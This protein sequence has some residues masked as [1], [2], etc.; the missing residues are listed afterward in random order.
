MPDFSADRNPVEQLAEEFAQ[1]Y[2]CGERPSLTDYVR[3][4]PQ[5]ADEIRELFP[6]LVAMEQLKPAT[7]DA[8]GAF[9]GS[10]DA[11]TSQVLDRLGDYRIVREVGRGGMGVVYEAEQESLGRHVA[12]KVL[13]PNARLNPTYLERFRREAKAAARLHHTNIVPVYGVGEEDGVHFYAMQFIRGEGL[14]RVLH[15][16]RRLRGAAGSKGGDGLL[17]GASFEASVAHNLLSGQFATPH[18][19]AAAPPEQAATVPVGG[20]EAKSFS[21]LSSAGTETAYFR[22]VA[23]VGLQVADALAYAHRQGVVHR[24]IKPSNLLLDAQGTVWVADF[25]LAKAEGSD[26][27]THTGDIVGTLRFMAPERF[28]GRSLPQSDIYSL[29]LTLYELLTLRPAFDDT[30]KGRLVDKVLHEPPPP[31][32]RLDPRVP[33][34]LETVVLKCVA[35]DP[36]ER[37][38]TADA[39][40]EEL[41]RFLADRPIRARR[42]SSAEK[43]WRWARRNPTVASLLGCVAL[44]LVTVAVVSTFSAAQM[45]AA[46]G[47]TTAAEREARLREAE[48]LLGQAH[49]TRYSR[50]G[51][52]RFETLAALDKAAAI[53]R[54]L[55]Q[56][57]QW[58]DRLR[59]EAIACLA[60]PDWRPLREWDGVIHGTHHW[61]CDD[62]HRLYARD[63]PDGHI[64]V[65]RVA[66]DEEIASLDGFPGHNWLG[67]S[68][69]G[70]FLLCG[71]G[72]QRRVWD[73]A[74]SPPALIVEQQASAGGPTFYPDGRHLVLTQT[75]GSILL[76]DL[77][78]PHRPPQLLAKFADGPVG[79]PFLAPQGDKL[80]VATANGRAVHFLELPSGNEL[81]PPWRPKVPIGEAGLAWHPGGRYLAAVS[82][83]P[84]RRIFIWDTARGQ[85]TAVLE[86]F[87]NGGNKIVFSPEGEFVVSTGWEGKLR[88]WHW[89]TG[90]Q[91]LSLPGGS[92]LRFSPE[93]G[94]IIQEENCLNLGVVAAG[95]EYRT[96]VQQSSPGKEVVYWR[97]AI[98][99]GGRLLA[100]A[101]RD[102]VRLWDLET[103]DEL[104]W[105]EENT[106]V[107]VAFAPDAL[108]TSGSAG[109]FLWPMRPDPQPGREWQIGPPRLLRSGISGEIDC[110]KDGQVI[111]QALKD[112]ALVLR[113]DRPEQVTRL[114]P[115]SDVRY[116]AISRDGRFVATGSH[117]DAGGLKIWETEHGQVVKERPQDH[118]FNEA[119]TFSPEGTWLAVEGRQG[120]RLLTVGTWE[121]GPAIPPG[122][123]A[124]SPDGTLLAVETHGSI[125][126]LD[127]STGREKAR[128]EDPHQDVGCWIGFTPDGRR[129]VAVS[130]D[131]KAIHVW[132]LKRIRTEL[133][134]LGLDWDAPPYP[135]RAD[136]AP[137][138]LEVQVVGAELPA[139]WQEAMTLNNEARRLATGPEGQRNPAR[140]L[141]LIQKAVE[142]DPDNQTF[143]NTL[144]VVQY[145]N[146][147]HK[148]AA[149]TLEKSL[150]AGKGRA[151]AFDLFFLAMCHAKLGEPA[152]AKDCFDRAVKWTEAQKD[153]PPQQIEELKAFRSEAEGIVAERKEGR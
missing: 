66:T 44:L 73:L 41:R 9:E 36:A 35:K 137:C 50:R 80:A 18:T 21:A 103:G 49:G 45:N 95:R 93:G 48:A 81:S 19:T 141:E 72:E 47:K 10:A 113:R 77:S 63:D 126:L 109:L 40:A 149:I 107:G 4:Y 117:G 144:G 43:L 32:R 143:L 64:S 6:A 152:K 2:R 34:D 127:P 151:D 59:Q 119:A 31:L 56:P 122:P 89:R 13:P 90:Q 65:R 28:D 42:A 96:L 97:A 125:R 27:L 130:E 104:A 75:N 53:G 37:Y 57:P 85:Q 100:V 12:L 112:G 20:T 139:K 142:R 140:A 55:G 121:E 147:Q 1:R 82:Q 129:L 148:E 83:F 29:G 62:Q 135:E 99:P 88:F 108:L 8:T 98:H 114:E 128:L 58:F 7:A 87:R 145:R 52:Q 5:H 3:R 120:S 150:A 79:Q 106:D 74:G 11:G 60:L 105:I 24:D 54:E 91:V 132:D 124:F 102:G 39:L 33:R 51:G 153:L 15:D 118:F 67:F 110:S 131:G 136:P 69:D 111:A 86:G 17:T 133:T 76:R 146:G 78:S 84:D 38:P 30:N 22:S 116:T 101:M 92:N 71:Q 70:R 123:A 115:Q 94:L 68:P 134:K 61:D 23:R 138:P 16:L 26:E 46:L 14:D 25:G